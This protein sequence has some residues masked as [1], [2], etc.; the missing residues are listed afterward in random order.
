MVQ[1]DIISKVIKTKLTDFKDKSSINEIAR[2]WYY[3]DTTNF[4]Y[5]VNDAH[6]TVFMTLT[7]E[8]RRYKI[9]S[10]HDETAKLSAALRITSISRD[11]DSFKWDIPSNFNFLMVVTVFPFSKN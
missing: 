9:Q 11:T 3:T 4:T 5:L 10:P 1:Q 2:E 6:V 7:R 8:S